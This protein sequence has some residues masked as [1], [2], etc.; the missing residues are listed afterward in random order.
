MATGSAAQ[1]AV[2]QPVVSQPTVFLDRDGTLNRERGFV[3]H[4]E[5]LEMVPGVPAAIRK[6]AEAGFRLVVLT[7]QS[8][9]AQGLYTEA[10]LAKVHAALHEELGG[11]PSAYL[12]CPH[13]PDHEG[14]PYGGPC[15]CRKPSD[16]LLGTG[17]GPHARCGLG[18][19]EER[20]DSPL[21]P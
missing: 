16:G 3:T 6:L 4:P 1:P 8:G 13:H 14:S 17:F 9:I 11:L 10:E 12:H 7:N 21:K 2:S 15:R 18:T 20:R 5:E 19:L